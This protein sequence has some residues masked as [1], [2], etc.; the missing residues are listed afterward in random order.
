MYSVKLI[1]KALNFPRSTYDESLLNHQKVRK[2]QLILI[3][4]PYGL[5]GQQI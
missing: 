3:R 5:E 1:C 2:K 4:N